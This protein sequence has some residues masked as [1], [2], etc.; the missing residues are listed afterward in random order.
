MPIYNFSW[1][2]LFFGTHVSIYT[3]QVS[4]KIYDDQLFEFYEKKSQ[5]ILK[6]E[7]L[8]VTLSAKMIFK[9]WQEN[10]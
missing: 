5:E 10:I 9:I 1:I 3:T 6:I 4:V 2:F 7:N 8:T